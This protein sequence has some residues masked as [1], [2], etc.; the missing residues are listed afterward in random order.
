LFELLFPKWHQ[1]HELQLAA[2]VKKGVFLSF[3]ELLQKNN[4]V[5]FFTAV[6]GDERKNP[7]LSDVIWK[8][9]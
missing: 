4:L 5:S 8:K 9:E 7:K 1:F 6:A 2:P 3:R